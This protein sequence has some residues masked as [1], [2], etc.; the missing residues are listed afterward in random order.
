MLGKRL[1]RLMEFGDEIFVSSVPRQEKLLVLERLQC[2]ILGKP[3]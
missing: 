1:N 2:K 3:I